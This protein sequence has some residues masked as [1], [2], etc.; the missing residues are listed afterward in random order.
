MVAA[1]AEGRE[2]ER[3]LDEV[4]ALRV[5][6]HGRRCRLDTLARAHLRDEQHPR[7]VVTRT[8]RN[9]LTTI[10]D[11]WPGITWT[12]EYIGPRNTFSVTGEHEGRSETRAVRLTLA[13]SL[14]D[15]SLAYDLDCACSEIADALRPPAPT[16]ID[17][18]AVGS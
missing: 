8:D 17:L 5:D 15:R 1:D 2:R 6:L 3:H 9:P 7:E 12:T 10:N 4:P 14:S 11:I 13:N 16:F 18:T